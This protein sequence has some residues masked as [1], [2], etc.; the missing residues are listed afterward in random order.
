MGFSPSSCFARQVSKLCPVLPNSSCLLSGSMERMPV[1]CQ[2]SSEE[3][4]QEGPG[5][6][7]P[8]NSIGAA[9]LL[10]QVLTW[11]LKNLVGEWAQ[12]GKTWFLNVK[13]RNVVGC[14][15][16][17]SVVCGLWESFKI[18]KLVPKFN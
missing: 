2:I 11:S 17:W 18:W 15:K 4:V 6:G 8:Y 7:L 12:G 13:C 5:P 10:L 16:L 14:C 1:K 3:L 9:S